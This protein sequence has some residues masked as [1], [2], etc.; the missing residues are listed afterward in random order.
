MSELE[1]I[2]VKELAS[3]ADQRVSQLEAI[4]EKELAS[5]LDQRMSQLEAITGFHRG[6]RRW[7]LGSKVLTY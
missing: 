6:L 2:T 7:Y 1:A 5:R 4:T 3:R